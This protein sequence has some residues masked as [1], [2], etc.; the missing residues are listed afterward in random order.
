LSK[1]IYVN[2]KNSK[3][4]WLGHSWKTG[5]RETSFILREGVKVYS[6]FKG[7]ET[8]LDQRDYRNNRTI[9]TGDLGGAVMDNV[10]AFSTFD[11]CEFSKNTTGKRGGAVYNFDASFITFTKCAFIQNKSG[12]GGGG[13]A[14]DF[15]AVSIIK[16]CSFT[17]NI[18]DQ[19]ENDID[20]DDRGIVKQ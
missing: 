11:N 16:D 14:T 1:I 20:K 10:G 8:S 12:L 5:N 7:D 9:L 2:A 6:G 13:I 3:G 15:D 18:S 19:G 4:P 17:S